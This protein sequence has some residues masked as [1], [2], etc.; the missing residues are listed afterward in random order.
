MFLGPQRSP[1]QTGRQSVQPFFCEAQARYKQTK[2]QPRYGNIGG[3]I[4]SVSCIRWSL[5]HS[6]YLANIWNGPV[7]HNA[8]DRFWSSWEQSVPVDLWSRLCIGQ[9]NTIRLYMDYTHSTGRTERLRKAELLLNRAKLS[10]YRQTQVWM[11]YGRWTSV[12]LS[13]L[14]GGPKKLHIS[15]CLMLNW[16]SFVKS[17]PNFIIFG[18]DWEKTCWTLLVNW[19]VQF[20]VIDTV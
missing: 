4:V 19:S 3:A 12:A 5:K 7:A 2:I 9:T 1:L 14:Q 6:L 15:S 18:W 13:Y 17:Q 20:C 11:P 10:I 8:P 16:Y